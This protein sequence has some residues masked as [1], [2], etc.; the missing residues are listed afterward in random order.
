M[1]KLKSQTFFFPVK[2]G[3][4]FKFTTDVSVTADGL[5]HLTIPEELA[6]TANALANKIKNIDIRHS[7]TNWT[8]IGKNLDDCVNFIK[9][10][11]D[12]YV[13]CE[14]TEEPVI[15]YGATIRAAYFKNPDGRIFPNGG[16]PGADH[17][18]GGRWCGSL[19]SSNMSPNYSVGFVA[20]PRIKTTYTRGSGQKV[21]YKNPGRD[22]EEY[23]KLLNSFCSLNVDPK[24][25]KEIPYTEE[26]AKFFFE[27]MLRLCH[28]A[29]RIET[30][31]GSKE[32]LAAAI[33]GHTHVLLAAP[34]KEEE[35]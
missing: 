9:S 19:S 21:E 34:P 20:V 32:T 4:E 6:P 2:T 16:F 3:G 18:K 24:S 1:A 7:R 27:T 35:K 17:G 33:A 23:W 11:G 26:A 5:F 12:D 28:L 22:G 31:F 10:A 15:L 14:V 25:L 8:V 13:A 30:F 29:D